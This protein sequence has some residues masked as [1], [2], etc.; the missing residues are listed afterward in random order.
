[1]A[2]DTLGQ[3][4]KGYPSD[5]IQKG[6]EELLKLKPQDPYKFL[7]RYFSHFSYKSE[8]LFLSFQILNNNFLDSG[9]AFMLLSRNSDKV[10][11]KDVL[12]LCSFFESCNRINTC[13]SDKTFIDFLDFKSIMEYHCILHDLEK[14][15]NSIFKSKSVISKQDFKN[16]ILKYSDT[17]FGQDLLKITFNSEELNQ[18][19]IFD[20]IFSKPFKSF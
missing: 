7:S 20:H 3:R 9:E 19:L 12:G 1:M 18:N 10:S 6:L 13:L 15:L 14:N 2:E 11:V 8:V 5:P 17:N 4:L 16:L